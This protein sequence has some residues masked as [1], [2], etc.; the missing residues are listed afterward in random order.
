MTKHPR[1]GFL[2]VIAA[3]VLAL[4]LLSFAYPRQMEALNRGL[5]VSNLGKSGVLVSWRLLGTEDPNTEFNLYRDGEKIA[6]IGKNDATN[7]LDKD[8]KMTSKYTVAAV[9]D[10]KEGIKKEP[11][12]VFDSTV[13]YGGIS[14]PY[15]VLK[16]D[17]PASQVMPYSDKTVCNY[18]P[19]DMSV[20]DLDGDGELSVTDITSL[21][22]AILGK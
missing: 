14:V 17:R 15:K 7:Y 19:D 9:I 10:G 21:V 6:S 8:G 11:S 3:L 1:H 20:G 4:P 5:V 16:L 13:A 22:N 18:Y 12:V 2:A